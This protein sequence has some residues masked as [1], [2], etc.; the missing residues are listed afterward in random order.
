MALKEG[1]RVLI[2][3]GCGFIGINLGKK[4][5][6]LGVSVTAFD[7]LITGNRSDAARAE[8]DVIEGD[9]R[10]ASALSRA[11]AG[12][13][14]VVHLAAH[15]NVVASVSDPSRDISVNVNGTLNALIAA[16]DAGVAGFVFAS[17]N[18]PLGDI[19]PPSRED[20][21][22]SPISPYGASKLSGEALCSAFSGSYGLPTTVLRFSNVYGPFSYHK[23]SVVATFMK[24]TIE[25]VGLTIYGDGNQTRDFVF[26]DDL[27]HG[28]TVALQSNQHGGIF[29]LGSG[30]ATPINQLAKRIIDMFP[31]RTVPISYAPERP[32]EIQHNY[33]DIS[34]ARAQLDFT[35]SH[36]LDSGLA[37]TRDWFIR[38]Y[39]S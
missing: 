31:D 8:L 18:A 16:R 26:V 34:K 15:T 9:I 33:S 30:V 13:D 6:S 20:V 28:I 32:G 4:L 7:S 10:D 14:Y 12:M 17:S 1:A 29:H 37:A 23:G 35:P 25:G 27:C 22:P 24:S 3:G 5:K 38:E 2:T 19:E 21:L 11:T 39:E 36:T